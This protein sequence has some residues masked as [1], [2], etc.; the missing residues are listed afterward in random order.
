MIIF[1][2]RSSDRAALAR[3]PEEALS[4]R[5]TTRAIAERILAWRPER[6][7][8]LHGFSVESDADGFLRHTLAWTLG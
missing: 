6:V 1:L 2:Y 3:G 5:R 4:D 8:V 7:I